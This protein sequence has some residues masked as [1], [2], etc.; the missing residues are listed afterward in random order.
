MSHNK[1][2]INVTWYGRGG[3]GAF[4]AARLLGTAYISDNDCNYALAFPSFGPERR[5]A[6]VR[7]FTKMSKLPVVSRNEITN[8]DFTVYLDSTLFSGIL[9]ENGEKAIVNTNKVFQDDGI[10]SF[11]GSNLSSKVLG[12]PISNTAM[13]GA[14]IAV[15]GGIS[16]DAVNKGVESTLPECL[17]EKNKQVV[18]AAYN[19][20]MGITS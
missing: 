12:S 4:T 10:I 7:A 14:L 3:Q 20:L 1:N 6:P 8:A 13:V 5:G 9:P 15:W 18:E 16:L 19:K 11:D 2:H 17:W